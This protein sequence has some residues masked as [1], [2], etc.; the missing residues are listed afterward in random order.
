MDKFTILESAI[1]PSNRMTFLLDWELTMKCNLDCGYCF[2]GHD[3]S[4]KHPELEKCLA[5]VEFMYKYVDTYMSYRPKG[6]KYVVLNVYG[7]ESLYHP[8]I[9]DIL[10]YCRD[11]YQKNFQEKWHLTI[12]CTTNAIVPEKKLAI[13]SEFI[14]EFTCSF[15]SETSAKNYQ[16]FRNN[17]LYLKQKDKR[18]KCIVVMHP[19]HFEVSE[20]MVNWCKDNDI[21]CLPKQIDQRIGYHDFDYDDYQSE[22]FKALYKSKSSKSSEQPIQ[23]LKKDKKYDLNSSGRSCCGGRSLCADKDYQQRLAFVSKK[24]PDWYCSVNHFFLFV[25]Q[26][27]GEIFVN[28]DC[29]MDFSG[30]VGPIGNLSE[31]NS[32]LHWTRKNLEEN[33]MPVIQCKKYHCRCGLC[34]PKA[35]HL[36]DYNDILRKYIK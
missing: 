10:K 28:K 11:Y 22:W 30:N 5:A 33:T 26:L 6:L 14:D 29:K 35:K 32:V 13:I 34:A 8:N 2:D 4:T 25:K 17:L 15:H 36:D 16:R 7:G 19:N 24:F 1:D 3:N 31:S 23:F 27:T 20:E 18:L 21:K 12:T 9:I